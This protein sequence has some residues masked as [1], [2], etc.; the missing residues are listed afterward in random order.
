MSDFAMSLWGTLCDNC[1]G[2]GE[3]VVGYDGWS[4]IHEP[5]C[6]GPDFAYDPASLATLAHNLA[7]AGAL[8]KAFALGYDLA[9]VTHRLAATRPRDALDHYDRWEQ[10][11]GSWFP[12]V[13]GKAAP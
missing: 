12:N 13:N 7:V 1:F 2:A 10:A 11:S 9:V 5:C 4:E 3:V 6:L 8:C